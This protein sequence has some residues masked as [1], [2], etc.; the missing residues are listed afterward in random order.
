MGTFNCELDRKEMIQK[1]ADRLNERGNILGP[2][3]QLNTNLVP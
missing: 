1:T 2:R 3:I